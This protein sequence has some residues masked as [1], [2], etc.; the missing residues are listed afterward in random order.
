MADA[1]YWA[2]SP[3]EVQAAAQWT[4][5]EFVVK[6][7]GPGEQGYHEKMKTFSLCVSLAEPKGELLV[8]GVSLAEVAVLD[9]WASWLAMGFDKHSLVADPQ[10]V[11]AAKD[12]YRLKPTSPAWSLGFK[13][14]PAEKIG[15][16]RDELRATWPIVRGG[17]HPGKALP[18]EGRGLTNIS[19][20]ASSGR[21]PGRRCGSPDCQRLSDRRHS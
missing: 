14:I 15:P 13:P 16:Y 17:G 12:D 21:W 3:D 11:D 8:D 2:S 1:F 10:F 5:C 6:I 9:P 18:P 20:T 4:P 7:P 19:I